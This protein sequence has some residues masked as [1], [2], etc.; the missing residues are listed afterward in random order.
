MRFARYRI[1]DPLKFYQSVN[2]IRGANL[3][4]SA[5]LQSALRRVQAK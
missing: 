1:E 4:L 2:S 3:R 5:L